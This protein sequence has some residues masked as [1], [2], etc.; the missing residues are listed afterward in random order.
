MT[1]LTALGPT[2][3]PDAT[4]L[5]SDSRWFVVRNMILLLRGVGDRSS[6]AQLRRCAEHPDLRVRLEAIKSL[7]VFDPEV[8]AELLRRAIHDRD[9]K[10]AEAAV[11]LAGTCGIH[12]AVAPLVDVLRRRD[13]FGRR[14]SL[15]LKALRALAKLGD[16]AALP[17]L[18]HFFVLRFLAPVA[19][20]ERRAAYASLRHYP[21]PARRPWVERGRR[22]RDPQIRETCERLARGQLDAALEET[23]VGP[24]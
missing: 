19:P 12:Q 4:Y 15:R 1:L 9:P 7:F 2:V 24:L 16:P 14:R 8:P 3:V 13:L 21:E 23:H 20:D 11:M 5:L 18:E 6:L 17:R 22:S 10:M